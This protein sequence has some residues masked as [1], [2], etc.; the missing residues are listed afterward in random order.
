MAIQHNTIAP[1]VVVLV[2]AVLPAAHARRELGIVSKCEGDVVDLLVDG[3]FGEFR[4]PVHPD[5][6]TMVASAS[7]ILDT[8]RLPEVTSGFDMRRVGNSILV[9]PLPRGER[10]FLNLQV[11][12]EAYI[13]SLDFLVVERPEL[14]AGIR[15]IKQRPSPAEQQR[16]M[17][18]AM[19]S[20]LTEGN[21]ALRIKG[22]AV[23]EVGGVTLRAGPGQMIGDDLYAFYEVEVNRDTQYLLSDVRVTA[24][25]T[26][27]GQNL[28]DVATIDDHGFVDR[29]HIARIPP[30]TRIRGTVVIPDA[31]GLGSALRFMINTPDGVHPVIATLTGLAYAGPLEEVVARAEE[32]QRRERAVIEE[33]ERQLRLARAESEREEA[34]REREEA[35]RGRIS[36]HIEALGGA[37]WLGDGLKQDLLDATSLK[38]L[39]V[40]AVYGFNQWVAFEGAIMGA[41]TGQAR[42]SGMTI[43]EQEGTL[44]RSASLGRVQFGGVLRFGYRIIPT[45]RLGVGLQGAGYDAELM[46]ATGSAPVTD[47][48]IDVDMTVN[49]GAG[50]DIRLGEHFMVGVA[51]SAAGKAS[52]FSGAGSGGAIEAGIHAGYAWKP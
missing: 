38:G 10:R 29:E 20:R 3:R 37:I 48:E 32:H 46:T 12:A 7:K 31:R 50:L 2:C 24:K 52:T 25:E 17:R 19:A 49:F 22:R 30:R 9:M 6:V 45:V 39:A 41:G 21:E 35:E 34:E 18:I 28:A 36:L 42:F 13:A 14:A 43:D 16:Q 40:R 4:I 33:A 15:R 11:T 44:V 27:M 26:G 5:K 8:L 47:S 23:A 1:L 51:A